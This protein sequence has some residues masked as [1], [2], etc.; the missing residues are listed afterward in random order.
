MSRAVPVAVLSLALAFAPVLAA[1]A[2]A[3]HRGWSIGA[4]FHVGGVH[5]V[6]AF[7]AH[8]RY[9]PDYYYRTHHRV[10]HRGYSCSDR[11]FR[12]S[13]YSYHHGS[14]PLLGRHFGVH[15]AYHAEV[16]DYY[17]PPPVWEGRYYG[18]YEPGYTDRRYHRDYDRY[19]SY[20]G[21]RHR[22]SYGRYDRGRGHGRHGHRHDRSCGYDWRHRPYR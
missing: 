10:H 2:E 11:C 19:E 5:F 18:S 20:D 1:P 4:G 17:A 3:G 12:Q 15:R 13:R 6:L 8:G 21:R 14:C 7:G 16:F 22:G 9:H